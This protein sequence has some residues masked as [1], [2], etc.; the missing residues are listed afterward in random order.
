MSTQDSITIKV[1]ITLPTELVEG[2]NDVVKATGLS[3][4]DLIT[5]YVTEGISSAMPGVKRKLFFN[6]T[7]EILRKH[8]IP[9]DV[10]DEI[11]EKFNY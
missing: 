5:R 9:D 1:C 11:V 8:N 6:C 3:Q 4:E 10:V 7:K 2:L